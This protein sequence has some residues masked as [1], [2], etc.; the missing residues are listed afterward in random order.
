LQVGAAALELLALLPEMLGLLSVGVAIE[1][2]A[3]GLG[4]AVN[5]LPAAT[6]LLG[7]SC[8]V[9]VAAVVDGGGAGDAV[10]GC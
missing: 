8:D 6:A 5:G 1:F 10:E 9:T 2:V 4:L 7:E 3:G